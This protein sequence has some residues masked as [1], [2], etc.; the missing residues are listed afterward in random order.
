MV[1]T[2]SF[3]EAFS[4]HKSMQV[5]RDYIFDRLNQDMQKNREKS[6]TALFARELREKEYNLKTISARDFEN[7]LHKM[8]VYVEDHELKLIVWEY[9]PQG[10]AKEVDMNEF[11]K[12]FSAAMQKDYKDDM[13]KVQNKR[14]KMLDQYNRHGTITLDETMNKGKTQPRDDYSRNDRDQS[15]GRD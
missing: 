11:Q 2:D 1:D 8:K 15:K 9:D 10:K 4:S 7:A 13:Y 3:L 14:H 12:D 6:L 5:V